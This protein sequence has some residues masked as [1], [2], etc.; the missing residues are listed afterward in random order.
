VRNQVITITANFKA[1]KNTR[2]GGLGMARAKSKVFKV[3]QAT[4]TF[5]QQI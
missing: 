1:K 2:P 3:K 5:A 4:K